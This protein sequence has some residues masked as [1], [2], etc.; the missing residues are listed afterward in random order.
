MEE[1]EPSDSFGH[2]EASVLRLG[3]NVRGVLW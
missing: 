3:P 1:P 2:T